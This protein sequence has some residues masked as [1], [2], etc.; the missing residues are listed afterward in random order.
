MWCSRERL[1]VL[2]VLGLWATC[3]H[4]AEGGTKLPLN[5]LVLHYYRKNTQCTKAEKLIT[6]AV[7]KAWAKD[8]SI[9]PALLR[10][11]YSD[12]FVRV[13]TLQLEF[14][15]LHAIQRDGFLLQGCD[16][17]ILLDGEGSEKE[18]PQNAG[19]RGFDVVDS[20][21]HEL[22]SKCPGVVS[23]AD[24]LHLAT[25]DAAGGWKYP[26]FTGRR[27]GYESDAKM[28]DLPPPSVSWDDALSYFK[29]RGL[30]VLDLGTL[31]G[32]HTLGVTHC[33]YVHDR[34]YNF[35]DTGLPDDLMDCRFA[36]QLAKTCPYRY[37]P[38]QPDPTVFLN[39]R[40]G[41]NF[42]FESSYYSRVLDNQAVLGIDQQLVTSKDGVRIA[43]EFAYEFD[44]FKRYFAL[45]ISRMGSVGVLTGSQG[46]I[47]RSCR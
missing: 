10:L 7:R 5:G 36:R 19:L 29:S 46:E 20:I 16:A 33:R 42:T 14:L 30:D 25:R 23:C 32:A 31:L 18:A 1:L 44:D 13:P 27:D 9:T 28:V 45:A 12:C 41:G 3:L 4:V 35:N 2:V 21:K 40:S 8:R 15:L 6:G 47:R 22:E 39:P 43:S 17:S 34:I 24:I 37:P 26:V 38:G 11:V